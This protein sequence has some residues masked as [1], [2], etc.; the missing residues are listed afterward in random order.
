M[1]FFFLLLL[2]KHQEKESSISMVL[3]NHHLLY[4]EQEPLR[5]SER[6]DA[7]ASSLQNLPN[8]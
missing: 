1:A 7:S 2:E 8:P 3:A 5:F 6:E 4:V